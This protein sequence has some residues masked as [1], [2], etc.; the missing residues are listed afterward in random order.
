M[1]FFMKKFSMFICSSV[2][3][4]QPNFCSIALQVGIF[5]KTQFFIHQNFASWFI[6]IRKWFKNKGW[7]GWADC[8]YG[9]TL[10]EWIH[11]LLGN[12][13]EK[14][15][16]LTNILWLYYL[17]KTCNNIT[18][19]RHDKDKR[20]LLTV[21]WQGPQRRRTGDG[22]RAGRRAHPIITTW[23]RDPQPAQAGPISLVHTLL[24]CPPIGCLARFLLNSYSV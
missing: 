17:P 4:L 11:N 20:G 9:F 19:T 12:S 5:N 13:S 8:H 10:T 18:L 21:R 2:R 23:S 7:I 14:E 16:P 6:M 3:I 22:L 1:W 15:F 24:T